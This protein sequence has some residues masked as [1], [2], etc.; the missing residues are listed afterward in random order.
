M[1]SC[2]AVRAVREPTRIRRNKKHRTCSLR[3]RR[4]PSEKLNGVPRPVG[5]YAELGAVVS[6]KV[7]GLPLQSIIMKA[8]LLLD[9]GLDHALLESSAKQAGE[10]LQQFHKATAEIPTK[11]LDVDGDHGGSSQSCAREAR[12]DGLPED[13]TDAP[14]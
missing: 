13:S 12:K 6:T 9:G 10:W 2:I 7:N 11:A 4:Q 5:D 14:S 1:R 3:I 8:A